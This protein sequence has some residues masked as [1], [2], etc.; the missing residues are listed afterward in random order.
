ML[1]APEPQQEIRIKW[2]KSLPSTSGTLCSPSSI[3]IYH[4]GSSSHHRSW[5]LASP[6]LLSSTL[7]LLRVPSSMETLE[8]KGHRR[9]GAYAQSHFNIKGSLAAGWCQLPLEVTSLIGDG[10]CKGPS[11][12]MLAT[13]KNLPA[14]LAPLALIRAGLL[15]KASPVSFHQPI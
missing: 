8:V 6:F 9:S 10:N 2:G 1:P 12:T 5:N 3:V 13:L 4:F 11:Q 7:A 14:S 15:H